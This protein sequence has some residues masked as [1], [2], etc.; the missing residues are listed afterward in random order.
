VKQKPKVINEKCPKGT[1]DQGNGLCLKP[2][3]IIEQA[4]KIVTLPCPK[5]TTRHYSGDSCISKPQLMGEN[6]SKPKH[7]SQKDV[8]D[9]QPIKKK[10]T[11]PK[12]TKICDPNLGG[13][14]SDEALAGGLWSQD[15]S[16]ISLQ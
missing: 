2:R 16:C 1:K 5:G 7:L 9:S 15:T 11:Q 13:I 14:M 12:T 10:P 3:K 8:L 4:P 6:I